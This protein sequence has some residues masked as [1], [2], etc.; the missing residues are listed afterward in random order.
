MS[1]DTGP[2]PS[3]EPA[4]PGEGRNAAAPAL[5][6]FLARAAALTAALTALGALLGLVRDQTIARL[7]GAGSETDAFLIAWTVP[8]FASTLL[9]EDAMALVLVPAFSLALSRRAAAAEQTGDRTGDRTAEPDPVRTL[10]AATLPRLA[11]ALAA[12]AALALVCAPLLV[13]LLAP[14]LHDPELA[15]QC[16]RLTALSLFTF[17]ITGYFSAALRAHRRFAPPA[18]VYTAYNLGIIGTV[19]ALHPVLGVRAAAAGVAVGS[20][21]MVLVQL[22]SFLSALPPRLPALGRRRTTGGPRAARRGRRP[23]VR[24]AGLVGL[25]LLAPVVLFALSRQSQV[26]VERFLGSTLPAGAISHLN[27]AQKVA[28]MPMVLSLM[29]CTVTFP[30]VARAMADGRREDARRRVEGDLALAA[31]IVLLGTAHVIALAPQL[32][33]ILFQRGAFTPADTDATA[34]VMR[35]YA[36]GL[37]GHTLVGALARPFFSAARPTWYPAA[38]MALGL[39]VTVVA[40]ALAAPH[41]GI[42]GIAA[43]NALGITGCAWLLLRGLATRVVPVDVAAAVGGLARLAVAAVAATA[44]GT[45]VA[46]LLPSPWPAAAGGALAVTVTFAVAALLLRAPEVPRLLSTAGKAVAPLTKRATKRAVERKVR[47]H[48]R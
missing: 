41:W 30:V 10:L 38:A 23:A 40:G 8:E 19:L 13:R 26:L 1:Q 31:A 21:L 34:S 16:T 20:L 3:A 14:G 9:V 45:A 15:V 12:V 46:A 48:G 37:L 25:G 47:R 42:H 4:P 27:Y 29:V 28:Q 35:V 17:G 2:R 32:I 36:L 44:A 22:P 5:G 43:A 39:L 18:A 7:F 24:T 33:E 11:A 6:R